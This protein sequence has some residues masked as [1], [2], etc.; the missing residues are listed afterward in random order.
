M[1]KINLILSGTGIVLLSLFSA[2]SDFEDHKAEVNT[3]SANF[4]K[5]FAVGNSITAGYQSSALYEEAQRYSYAV[6]LASKVNT[7]FQVPYVSGDGLG[8]RIKWSG[9]FNGS[10]PAFSYASRISGSLTSSAQSYYVSTGNFNNLGVPGMIV[11]IP[12]TGGN[13]GD[14]FSA[15]AQANP[16][17]SVRIAPINAARKNELFNVVMPT[18]ARG[19]TIWKALKASQPT[20]VSLWLGNNDVLGYA[21]SGGTNPSAPTPEAQ[22]TPKFKAMVDSIL[23]MASNPKMVVLNTPDVTSL[24]FF[25]TVNPGL[26]AGLEKAGLT[27]IYYQDFQYQTKPAT[28]TE[29]KNYTHMTTLTSAASAGLVGVATGKPWRDVASLANVSVAQLFGL[30]ASKGISVPDTTK[31]FAAH[32]SNPWPNTFILDSF[33]KQTAKD[34]TT[35]INSSIKTIIDDATRSARIAEVDTYWQFAG[36]ALATAQG[37]S[38]SFQGIPVTTVFISG[39]LFSYDGVHPSNLGQGIIANFIINAVNAKFGGNI[40]QVE[41]NNL[42]GATLSKSSVQEVDL[43]NKNNIPSAE[44]LKGMLELVRGN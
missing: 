34:A 12:G 5:Y 31:P 10:S 16:S 33:E 25:T 8:G 15:T 18:G 26:A 9:T 11:V 14:F 21:T 44:S 39:G 3:G 41:L 38:I 29:L 40:Q 32:P 1:K 42:S 13:F 4:S 7:S 36:I 30:W 6:Q 43:S 37:S 20:F 19:N 23:A 22:F 27:T 35:A 17:D 28:V 2:C 24:P